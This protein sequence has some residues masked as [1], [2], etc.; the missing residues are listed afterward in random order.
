MDNKVAVTVKQE[1]T[2]ETELLTWAYVTEQFFE[3]LKKEN[4]EGQ[5]RNFKTAI[6]F[7]LES[8]GL[9]EASPVGTELTEEFEA[10]IDV[11][12]K[13]HIAREVQKSTYDPRVSKIR[14]LKLF[15]DANFS[16]ALRLQ[17]LPE[18]FG[19]RLSRLINALGCTVKSFWRTLPKGL[20]NYDTLFCWCREKYLPSRRHLAAITTMEKHLNVP[21][22]T[23]RLPKYLIGERDVKVGRSDFGNKIRAALAKPYYVSTPSL[24]EEFQGW[25]RHKTAAILPEGEER[26]EKG[27]W[28]SSE[29]AGFPTA[30]LAEDLL[31]S[32]MGY[33]S[34]PQD[35]PDPFLKGQGLKPKELTMAL[36]A[37]K[38]L[39]E[40]Y[41]EFIRLRSGLRVRPVEDTAK[42]MELPAHQISADGRWE[43]YNKGGKYNKRSLLAL[44]YISSLLRPGTGYL[45]QHPEFAEKLGPQMKAASWQ[46][47][48][49]QTRKRVDVLRKQI[50][51]MEK[52]NDHENYDFG[53]DPKAPIEWILDLRRPLLILQQL[54]RDMLEDLLPESAPMA[55]RARQYRDLILVA[56]LCANPLR[57]RMFSIMEFGKHLVRR[58]DGSWWLRF[59]K[60]AFK[61][62]R[63]L[64]SHYEV[65]VAR[66]LWH[67]LDRYKE[68]FHPY[69]TRAT[70]SKH[71]FIGTAAGKRQGHSMIASSLGAVVRAMT[72]LY[73]PGES[74]FGPHAFRHIIATDIIKKDPRLGFF[75]ASVALHD[76]LE[77]VEKEYIHLKSSEFFEPVNTHFG[78]TWSLVFGT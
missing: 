54:I 5:V 38:E 57:I 40:N 60:R 4:K 74:G 9:S 76:K 69:L 29:G 16:S 67:M 21:A 27:Q 78:E 15:V 51:A 48:C 43:F 70:G 59:H 11:Y 52:G 72:E 2:L 25:F 7:F 30:K 68:E 61:N 17:T 18:S 42:K 37:D 1:Q 20:V 55:D 75:L 35:S 53:R 50:W 64:K 77:T 32:F 36:L 13:F 47:Q 34:L 10:K 56:M 24:Q 26:H 44:T 71:V 65:R 58:D 3:L 62:R 46:E 22:G 14:K 45:Y 33:C 6:K 39:V 31:K 19:Q 12:I 23:L 73:V 49:V 41:L 8:S 66:E 63:A 28:T